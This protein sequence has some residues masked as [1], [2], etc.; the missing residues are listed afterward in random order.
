MNADNQPGARFNPGFAAVNDRLF[1]FGGRTNNL[2]KSN[3]SNS[4]LSCGDKILILASYV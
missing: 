3:I 4:F 2:C 1:L